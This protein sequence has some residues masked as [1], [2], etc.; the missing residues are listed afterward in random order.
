MTKKVEKSTCKNGMKSSIIL[1]LKNVSMVIYILHETN[2]LC[3]RFA[4]HG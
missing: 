1:L 3:E 4:G 2:S